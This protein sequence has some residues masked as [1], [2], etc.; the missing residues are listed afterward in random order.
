MVL[1]SPLPSR[2][3][4]RRRGCCLGTSVVITPVGP[5]GI[6]WV[7][8][9]MR[10]PCPAVLGMSPSSRGVEGLQLSPRAL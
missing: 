1:P 10:L 6:E 4:P 9:G 3:S 2:G 5:P 7:G 8:S